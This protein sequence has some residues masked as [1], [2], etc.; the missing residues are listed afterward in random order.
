[1]L[2]KFNAFIKFL[3]SL[4]FG[5]E[6]LYCLS[7][8]LTKNK[9]NRSF[10][11]SVTYHDT[12]KFLEASL[13]KQF[14][15]YQSKFDNCSFTDMKFFLAGGVWKKKKPGIVITFDDGL[16]S[17][18]MVASRLLDEFGFTGWFMVPAGV[19]ELPDA[20]N[21]NFCISNKID[22]YSPADRE[23]LFMSR[24]DLV[25][26]RRRGH[27]V[28]SHSFTHI[29]LSDNL[30]AGDLDREITDSKM[31]LQKCIGEEIECFAWVG[32]EEYSYSKK[33]MDSIV[34][35]KYKYVFS[36]NCAPIYQKENPFLL[37]RYHVDARYTL[38]EVR[39]AIG[40]IY[41]LLYGGKRRRVRSILF[42]KAVGVE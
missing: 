6:I 10:L 25:D 30:S 3:L 38:S 36:G 41:T 13:R 26:L 20:E 24:E 39:L 42:P 11:I 33:T 12:P 17:N 23:R 35:S 2:F 16:A 9:T 40:W 7:E 21:L 34:S 29:R 31:F 4:T 27:E 32:G 37:E 15:W 19:V 22:C 1:M 5:S 28:V 8:Y 14:A 18:Y